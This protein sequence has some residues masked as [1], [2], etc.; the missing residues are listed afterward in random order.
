MNRRILYLAFAA[1]AV[2]S[3]ISDA[4][5]QSTRA[6]RITTGNMHAARFVRTATLLVDGRHDDT[7]IT[8]RAE[9]CDSGTGTWNQTETLN[10]S[11][12]GTARLF[13]KTKRD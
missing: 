12:H 5:A 4:K 1:F 2:I 11:R 9:L 8:A 13:L 7:L 10:V 3:S 6:L